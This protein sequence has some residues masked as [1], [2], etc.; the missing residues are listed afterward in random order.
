MRLLKRFRDVFLALLPILVIVLLIHFFFYRFD[1]G[2]LLK[3]LL[4]ILFI[5][6]GEIMFL[7]GVDSTIFPIGNLMV[8]SVNKTLKFVVFVMF[9]MIFG[10]CATIAE[11]DV[12]V[13]TQQLSI[14][15]IGVSRFWL[16]FTIGAGVG[17]FVGLGILRIMKNIDVKYIYL[18][19]F[20][21]IFVLC[22]QVKAELIAVAFDAG[23]A[24]T[25]IISAPF[26]LAISSGLAEK[27]H[28]RKN[29]G[30]VF[31]MVGL[32]ALGPIV[33]VLFMFAVFGEGQ[34]SNA[35]NSVGEL[36]IILNVLK[37]SLL[38]VIPLM[39][40]FYLYDILIIKLPVKKKLG[41]VFGFVIT[42][43]GLF[44][45]LFGIDFG[46]TEMAGQMGKFLST[47]SVPI[48]IL[49]SILLGFIITFSEPSVIVLAKRVH[50]ATNGNIHKFL[51]LMMI[52]LSMAF[53]ILLSVLKIFYSIN[54]FYIILIG[55]LVALV[56]MFVV[57]SFFTGL[58][59]DSGGVA[60]GPMCSAF[61]LPMM[62]ALA[63]SVST[64]SQ[65]FGLVGIV[66]MSPIIV[67]QILG[68]V[69]KVEIYAKD[70]KTEK[71]MLKLVYSDDMYS[72]M[73]NL[74]REH[75]WLTKKEGARHEKE[76]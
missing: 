58:A 52:A 20:A 30:E 17:L 67:I 9:A 16:I 63:G 43:V 75:E 23:G 46:V 18:I 12:T 31:G 41:F 53:S 6:V 42:F 71:K 50:V 45:F 54:F 1:N 26:L 8:N 5:C 55:Y 34:V 49:F 59:F 47:L 10:V 27:S 44:L 4:S 22:T 48:V 61:I 66:A 3:F 60:S 15:G 19:I 37:N 56:L 2:V 7:T 57:P 74:E 32:A 28:E 70:R 69:Y 64:S 40:V 36:N 25:G 35:L 73:E 14:A 51:V 38:A 68:L 24:T 11:P 72:N 33:A 76:R 62:I 65:G 29:N 13:L 39:A 21:L